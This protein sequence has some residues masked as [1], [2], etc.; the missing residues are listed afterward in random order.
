M[1]T[2]GADDRLSPKV[3][4][5]IV[6]PN[7]PAEEKCPIEKFSPNDFPLPNADPG[8]R[9]F[10]LPVNNM[11]CVEECFRKCNYQLDSRTWNLKVRPALSKSIAIPLHSR[12]MEPSCSEG[13]HVTANASGP[14]TADSED[15][16][17][18]LPTEDTQLPLL[19][20]YLPYMNWDTYRDYC[21]LRKKY[22]RQERNV[23]P[24]IPPNTASERETLEHGLFQH[25]PLHP[26][27]TLDQ[28]YYSSLTDT[29]ARDRDQTISKWT[30][31][32]IDQDGRDSAADDSLLIMID[33]L[34]CWVLDERTV[35]SFFPSHDSHYN[36]RDFHDLYNSIRHSM[37]KCENVWDM[38]S[39]LVKEATTYLFSQE[40]RKLIDLIETYRWVT[41][42]KA[43]YQTT[44][45]QEFHQ[46]HSSGESSST[47][48]DDRR[49]LKLVL[50]IADII[51]ELKMIRHLIDKQREVLKSLILALVKLNSD[52]QPHRERNSD[53]QPLEQYNTYNVYGT[54]N[55]QVQNRQDI[56]YGVENTTQGVP[57]AARDH[58][59]SADA[60]LVLLL[61][62]IDVIKNDAEYA[63]K[64]LL[65][66]LDL[67]Q[68][69][70]SLAEARSTTQ[71]GRAVM[72]FTIVT[73]IFL[74]LSFFTSYFGQNVSEITG[75]DKNPSTWDLW[76]IGTPISL[77]VIL[78][79]L[80][81][82]YYI[83]KP[84]SQLWC[85]R[86]LR[87]SRDRGS[88]V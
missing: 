87:H 86:N 24:R 42:K 22:I 43:A 17:L 35:L 49:E 72:L 1:A 83:T 12:H 23:Q 73:V 20:L 68:K 31:S 4:V 57:G 27:R 69:T 61:T 78:V 33:Q 8:F 2:S 77:V 88:S 60:M 59:I 56:I 26:R 54:M 58:V 84:D 64:M 74:P 81:I 52:S 21:S 34:W 76:R 14:H 82:A 85:W 30:G 50:E 41:G 51:D 66:L 10:H 15:T 71:Q 63:H 3:D 47:F 38:Y 7:N 19:T 45:F 70:A 9:W 25:P 44:Y 13:N 36:G 16:D 67:K 5:Y 28:F 80:L 29:T 40:N 62:E 55:I 46:N 53:N 6:R 75:D 39:L 79:A 65:D 48:L 18:E 37:N 11:A 32:D